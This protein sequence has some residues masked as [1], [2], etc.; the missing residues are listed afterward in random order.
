M[1]LSSKISIIP[2]TK[3]D[4]PE[5]ANLS[6]EMLKYQNALTDNYF[7]VF[8]YEKYLKELRA[9]IKKLDELELSSTP[10]KTLAKGNVIPIIKRG[11]EKS[12][13]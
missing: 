3:E 11:R 2:A 5:I 13:I 12:D 4:I 1:V 9:E 8:P 7:T 6:M 10:K